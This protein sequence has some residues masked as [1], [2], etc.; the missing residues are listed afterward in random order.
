LFK[1]KLEALEFCRER[2]G[3]TNFALGIIGD[4]DYGKSW[5]I[6]LFNLEE[7]QKVLNEVAASIE[8]QNWGD[9]DEFEEET[10]DELA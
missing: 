4:S 10:A 9:V 1:T 8:S 6:D 2:V 7:A 3:I 5:N